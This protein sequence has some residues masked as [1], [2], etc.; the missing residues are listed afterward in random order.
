MVYQEQVMQA[1]QVLAGYTLGAADVLRRAMGKKKPEEMAKQRSAFV[2]GCQETHGILP[3]K[4]N[5]IFDLLEKFAGYGFNK[6][7]AAAYAMVAYQTAYLKANWPV[8]FLCAM[9]TNDM[10][11]TDKL[12]QYIAEARLA[13]IEV[14]GPDVNESQVHFAPAPATGTASPPGSADPTA[15]LRAIRF[16]LAAIKGVG[17]VAVASILDAR[18]ERGPFGDLADFCERVDTRSVNRK[19]IELLIRCGACDCFGD[20]RATLW[21][22]LERTLGR[23]ASLALDR[24]RGQTSLF[25]LLD[26]PEVPGPTGRQ[27]LPEWPQS[28][29]LAAEKELL[30]F[31]VTGH[32]LTP[33]ARLLE[34]F[35]LA[36]TATLGQLPQRS[37]TR[38]GGL[39]TAVQNGIS[40]K[41]GK[42]Y[43]LA[44]LDDLAGSVQI[45]CL[46]ESY[47][48]YRSLLGA[49][50]A[51]L[52]VAEISAGDERPKLFPQEILALEDAPQRYTQQVHLRLH[53][54]HLTRAKL[55][56]ARE[57]VQQ[58]PGACPLF[59]CLVRPTGE[60][61]FIESHERFRVLPSLALQEAADRLFG[62]ATYFDLVD[63][64]L[65]PRTAWR[66]DRREG[67]ADEE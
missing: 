28:E 41:T 16:G 37:M 23:A 67:A 56:S 2:S 14:L 65:P 59:L 15:A 30:G 64:S 3:D 18:R 26:G 11:D 49:N 53:T 9:M 66:R 21:G 31:F 38:I 62:E 13:G 63:T 61:V 4:A 44:T 54:A 8:E 57:L 29:L 7:H 58:H 39:I 25:S 32:P 22:G 50:R 10:G 19:V 48:R 24:A 46:N 47:E 17:E 33:Y 12:G 51:V 60:A 42:P 34:K 6:S 43:A 1:A 20:T 40:K 55:E 5:A 45:L 27:R 35:S 52:V 36:T